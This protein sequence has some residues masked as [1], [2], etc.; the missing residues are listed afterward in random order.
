[1]RLTPLRPGSPRH[2]AALGLAASEALAL[3]GDTTVDFWLNAEAYW[4][5]AKGAA[6]EWRNGGQ[7]DEG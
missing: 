5:T 7:P 6:L 2:P 1:V 4:A 3:L